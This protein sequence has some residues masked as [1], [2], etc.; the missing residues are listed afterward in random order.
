MKLN[1]LE[2][3]M[4]ENQTPFLNKIPKRIRG[5][6]GQEVKMAAANIVQLYNENF[7]LT[8]EDAKIE[9]SSEVRAW[10]L[11]RIKE[12]G[13]PQH[14]VVDGIYTLYSD[15]QAKANT[16]ATGQRNASGSSMSN[17]AYIA[18]LQR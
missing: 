14:S 7:E 6:V 17:A 15:T 18:N 16:S 5:H 9:V 10:F 12:M 1:Q 13:W 4:S 8:E 11:D 3:Y 2:N